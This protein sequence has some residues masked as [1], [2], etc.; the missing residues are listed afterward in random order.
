MSRS[1]TMFRA[2]AEQ[3][4]LPVAHVRD[5]CDFYN[6]DSTIGCPRLRVTT[7]DWNTD[8]VALLDWRPGGP[9]PPGTRGWP[10]RAEV[11]RVVGPAV[12]LGLVSVW[13][14][15]ERSRVLVAAGFYDW[16]TATYLVPSRAVVGGLGVVAI[17]GTVALL[18]SMGIAPQRIV[19]AVPNFARRRH[20]RV[21]RRVIRSLRAEC[22]AV[23]VLWPE[24]VGWG[25]ADA[26]RARGSAWRDVF[27]AAIRDAQPGH[28][29]II[30]TTAAS[31]GNRPVA[32]HS[33][34]GQPLPEHRTV[35]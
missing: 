9:P 33:L 31:S 11:I 8:S 16:I 2:A 21:V 10:S 29:A 34:L 1:V 15:P 22:P 25:I 27:T 30:P 6:A 7:W 35:P 14:Q 26:W 32:G 28:G 17:T 23:S 13:D 19:V 24:A 4:A 20:R 5:L 3:L 18:V 12:P